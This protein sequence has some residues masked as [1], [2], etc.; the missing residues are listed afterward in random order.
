MG[1]LYAELD[2]IHPFGDGNS[3]TLRAFTRQLA[4]EAG[5]EIDWERF[6][7]DEFGRDLLYI[8]RDRSVNEIAYLHVE[9]ESTRRAIAMSLAQSRGNRDMADLLRDI[10]RPRR[11]PR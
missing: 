1:K 8:A 3:R 6:G 11:A 4:R 9:R 5:Y 7:S 10:V 2:Y